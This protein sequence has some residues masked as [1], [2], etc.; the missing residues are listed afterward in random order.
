MAEKPDFEIETYPCTACGCPV[1]T[2]W[3]ADNTGMLPDREVTL[4]AD[5]VF[6]SVCWDAFV[7]ANPP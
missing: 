1:A 3:A 4:V 2:K 6:H 5:S 7:A